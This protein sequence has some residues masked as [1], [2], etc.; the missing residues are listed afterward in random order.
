MGFVNF[1]F[2]KPAGAA[3]GAAR[4]ASLR[5]L[6]LGNTAKVVGGA[7]AVGTGAWLMLDPKGDEKLGNAMNN[8]GSGVGSGVGNLF[9]GLGGGLMNGM[10]GPYLIPVC[11]GSCCS[12]CLVSVL[13]VVLMKT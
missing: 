1:L 3:S 7:A 10:F 9:G 13:L 11:S 6:K 4:T 5:N 2:K 8:L 12:L